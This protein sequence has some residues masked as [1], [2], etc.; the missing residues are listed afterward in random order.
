M[1]LL[2]LILI[3]ALIACSNPTDSNEQNHFDLPRQFPLQVG[4]AWVYKTTDYN[5]DQNHIRT[6]TLYIYGKYGDSYKMSY[7]PSSGFDIVV[8]D[9]N[10]LLVLGTVSKQNEPDTTIYSRPFIWTFFNM[11]SGFVDKSVFK[12]YDCF[13]D[14]VHISIEY[15]MEFINNQYDVY[16]IKY[17]L[18]NSSRWYEHIISVDGLMRERYFMGDEIISEKIIQ[19]KLGNHFPAIN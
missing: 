12:N 1:K 10:K 3:I 18:K 7:H 13:T 11:D 6:D 2:L 4:N 16:V 15:G 19:S 9:Q 17:Y 5:P 14:S 8:N